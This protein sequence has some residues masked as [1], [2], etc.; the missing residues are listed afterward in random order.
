MGHVTEEAGGLRHHDGEVEGE[1]HSEA[2]VH[3]YE[4]VPAPTRVSST[5]TPHNKGRAAAAHPW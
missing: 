4:P 3:A 1:R 5:A 2:I